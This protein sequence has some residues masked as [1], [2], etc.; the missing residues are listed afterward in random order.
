MKKKLSLGSWLTIPHQ[1]V[2]E[3]L[4][5]EKKIE[6]IVI[7]LEHTSISISDIEKLV[8]IIHSSNK[9]AYVRISSHLSNDIKKTLDAG[10]DGIIVPMV[11]SYED[12]KNIINQ[13]YFPPQGSRSFSFCRATGY[14]K[15]FDKY[16]KKFNKKIKIIPLI[17]HIDAVNNLDKI[18]VE[19][20][21]DT[22]LIGP[23]DLSGSLGK[24]G[25]FKNKKFINS[26]KKIDII[27]KKR[28]IIKGIH[29]PKLDHQN[30]N[31]FVKNNFR[32]IAYGMDTQFLVKS[33]KESFKKILE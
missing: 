9:K 20:K 6:W 33:I 8:Q 5:T 22:I 14:G 10:A 19:K 1:Y 18:L 21:I 11:K 16:T 28:K 7:D 29:L 13:S 31:N 17:E 27:C 3:I 25:D 26:L 24:S 2:L 15:D 32:F 23:Y 12:I 30:F 4:L